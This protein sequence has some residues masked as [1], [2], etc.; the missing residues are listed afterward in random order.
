MGMKYRQYMTR[1]KCG[2]LTRGMREYLREPDTVEELF[3]HFFNLSLVSRVDELCIALYGIGWT[4]P[5]ITTVM[6][7]AA[8]KSNWRNN[9]YI[10]ERIESLGVVPLAMTRSGHL[11]SIPK[12]IRPDKAGGMKGEIMLWASREGWYE[13]RQ[14]HLRRKDTKGLLFRM[15]FNRRSL[16]IELQTHDPDTNRKSWKRHR[17]GFYSQLELKK[18]G[19]LHGLN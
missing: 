19:G 12:S 7:K 8:A 10:Q 2:D 15:K 4:G 11:D 13:D 17:S 16:R 5:Q 14:G 6:E 3:M 1:L 9:R 18:D